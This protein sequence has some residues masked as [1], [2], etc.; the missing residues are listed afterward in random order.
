MPKSTFPQ[1]QK[2][3][4]ITHNRLVKKHFRDLN[5]NASTAS[6]NAS[7][8]RLNLRNELL[9]KS[10]DSGI[11]IN[12]KLTY[13]RDYII[14]LEGT[15]IASLPERWSIKPLNNI[16]ELVI[17]FRDVDK[18]SKSGNYSLHIPHYNGDKT[19]NISSYEKGNWHGSLILKDNSRL[20]VNAKNE[21]EARKTINE[22]KKYVEAKYIN[23]ELYIVPRKGKK[24]KEFTAKP[25]RA[26]YYPTGYD[27]LSPKWR[28][29]F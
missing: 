15:A 4:L 16:P 9:I 13:F 6:N 11:I 19:P 8:A 27:D 17:V 29:Y 23:D 12:L 5:K 3:I 20:E 7:N 25:I 26:D 22:L 10:S 1:L 21:A 28:H 18:K 24:L 14:Q 2:H